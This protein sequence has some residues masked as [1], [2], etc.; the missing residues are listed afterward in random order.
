VGAKIEGADG[1]VDQKK[2]YRS[3]IWE[4]CQSQQ[5]AA[6]A[7]GLVAPLFVED[8][9]GCESQEVDFADVADVARLQDELLVS[10]DI[11]EAAMRSRKSTVNRS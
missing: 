9:G 7:S 2:T 8:I 5:R 1:G 3:V 10:F 11:D 6:G 4:G